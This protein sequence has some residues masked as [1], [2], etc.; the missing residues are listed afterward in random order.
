MKNIFTFIIAGIALLSAGSCSNTGNGAGTSSQGAPTQGDKSLRQFNEI[1]V[2][3][4]FQVIYSQGDKC[5]VRI[6]APQELKDKV[7]TMVDSKELTISTKEEL[8]GVGT[9]FSASD[10]KVYVISPSIKGIELAGAGSFTTSGPIKTTLLDIDLT[11]S[12]LIDITAS[13]TC[14]NLEVELTG[15]GNV[16]IADVKTERLKTK[17]TGTGDV[18]YAM[19]NAGKVESEITGTGNIILKGNAREHN[20]SVTGTGKVDAT[21]LAVG[22]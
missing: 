22:K 7:I 21:G 17:V 5:A 10:V 8:V 20:Q 18:N 11:G 16:K 2:A 9:N 3:G 12:G 6:E 19:L 13:T 4:A 15:S 1:K 14:T